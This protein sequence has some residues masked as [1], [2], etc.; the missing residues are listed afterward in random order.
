LP[1]LFPSQSTTAAHEILPFSTAEREERRAKKRRS[2]WGG[3]EKEKTFIPGMPTVLPTNLS[4]EQEEAYLG[5]ALL[6][7]IIFPPITF[8]FILLSNCSRLL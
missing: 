7:I 2:R 4:K 6:F 1:F 5:K 3:D 8:N